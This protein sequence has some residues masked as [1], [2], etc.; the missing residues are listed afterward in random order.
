M[1]NHCCEAM[2]SRVNAPC[3]QHD[4]PSAC[5]DALVGFSARFQEYGLIIH[6]GGTSRVR[7]D[8]CPWCGRRLPESQRDR[9]FDELERRG[10]DPW[11]DE[12]PAEFLDGSWIA[13]L[14]QAG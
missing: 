11:E 13:A 2:N 3:G 10:I 9:W 8:F 5:P 7:I 12:V 1:A 14:S 6:D 4:D